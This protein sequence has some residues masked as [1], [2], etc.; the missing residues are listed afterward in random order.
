MGSSQGSKYGVDGPSTF[1][2]AEDNF[3]N[4]SMQGD[5]RK[6]NADEL[7]K[8]VHSNEGQIGSNGEKFEV[9]SNIDYVKEKFEQERKRDDHQPNIQYCYS[10]TNQ[11]KN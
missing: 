5:K 11:M 4:A 2:L 1:R 3:L 8:E 9:C 7:Y 6:K 10:K